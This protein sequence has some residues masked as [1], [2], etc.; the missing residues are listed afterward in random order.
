MAEISLLKYIKWRPIGVCD[1]GEA[2]KRRAKIFSKVDLESISSSGIERGNWRGNK[3]VMKI[4][5]KYADDLAKLSSLTNGMSN[6]EI[7]EIKL[8]GAV[9]KIEQTPNLN[10]ESKDGEVQFFQVSFKDSKSN[11]ISK[12]NFKKFF[13]WILIIL[14][15]IISIVYVYKF[16]NYFS[17]F[18]LKNNFKN[19]KGCGFKR[20]QN[21]YLDE[22]KNIQESMLTELSSLPKWVKLEEAR[23]KCLGRSMHVDIQEKILLSCFISVKN[24]TKKIEFSLRPNFRKMES[25]AISICRKNLKHLSSL[26]RRL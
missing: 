14:G 15:F 7:S 20:A 12:Y 26:C 10:R 13:K 8:V 2:E 24:R 25:C 22:L 3:K 5:R 18:S 19:D 23:S 17:E 4:I 9:L 21:F 1:T 6:P 11:N 16:L